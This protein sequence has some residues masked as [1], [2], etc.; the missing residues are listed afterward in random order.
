[1]GVADT[2]NDSLLAGKPASFPQGSGL[3]LISTGKPI[4]KHLNNSS[5]C[6]IHDVT[7]VSGGGHFPY[8]N[9]RVT[10]SKHSFWNKIGPQILGDRPLKGKQL[11]L[12]V[13]A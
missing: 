6:F 12:V 7:D 3:P 5:E 2:G 11:A 13:F 4:R 9:P 1:M 8:K 10:V